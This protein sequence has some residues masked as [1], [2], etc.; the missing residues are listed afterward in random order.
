MFPATFRRPPLSRFLP[1]PP[2]M[3]IIAIPNFAPAII[4]TGV[5]QG[6]MEQKTEE[7]QF[8]DNITSPL[9]IT[10]THTYTVPL[11]LARL[12]GVHLQSMLPCRLLNFLLCVPPACYSALRFI[13]FCLAHC[14]S[15]FTF[16]RHAFKTI[17]QPPHSCNPKQM[18][19]LKACV[20][21]K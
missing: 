1:L 2:F 14:Y 18:R 21:Y 13:F 8:R 6:P 10:K 3:S 16:T 11:R 20:E 15:I 19:P 12:G 9:L 4:F 7:E 5:Y 17:W